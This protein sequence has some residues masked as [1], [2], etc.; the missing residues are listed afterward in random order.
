MVIDRVLACGPL[1][2]IALVACAGPNRE[3]RPA[4]RTAFVTG[5]ITY[6]ERVALRT[7]ALAVIQLQDVSRVDAPGLVIGE[8][9]ID[10]PGQVPIRFQIRYNPARIDPERTYAISAR[11]FQGDRLLFINDTTYRVITRGNPTQIEMTLQLVR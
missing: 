3:S 6:R 1:L 10:S 9:R 4:E 5:T 7:D 11:I 2:A 8:Q